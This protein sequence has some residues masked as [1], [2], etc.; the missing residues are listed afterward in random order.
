MIIEESLD[1]P[2]VDERSRPSCLVG[3]PGNLFVKPGD[4]RGNAL[5]AGAALFLTL[6]MLRKVVNKEATEADLKEMKEMLDYLGDND[7]QFLQYFL[8]CA[9]GHTV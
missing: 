4:D 9:R 3:A 5:G 7:D 1:A 8:I 2:M 6:R